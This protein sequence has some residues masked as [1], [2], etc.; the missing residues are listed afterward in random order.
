MYTDCPMSSNGKHDFVA[1]EW[2]QVL[3]LVHSLSTT[4][5]MDSLKVGPYLKRY[6]TQQQLHLGLMFDLSYVKFDLREMDSKQFSYQYFIKPK[7][8]DHKK[9][10]ITTEENTMKRTQNRHDSRQCLSSF[11][12]IE[13]QDLCNQRKS[14]FI[15]SNP[16]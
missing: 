11:N 1:C 15:G 14:K 12:L 9:R 13:N 8:G 7:S 2:L 4:G 3:Q 6:I 16:T 5:K 10:V